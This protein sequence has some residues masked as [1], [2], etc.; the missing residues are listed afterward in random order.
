MDEEKPDSGEIDP[1]LMQNLLKIAGM[2]S[3]RQQEETGELAISRLD[4]GDRARALDLAATLIR[5]ARKEASGAAGLLDEPDPKHG[6]PH[7]DVR[8]EAPPEN[9]KR[10]ILF[11]NMVYTFKRLDPPKGGEKRIGVV[12]R[13]ETEIEVEGDEPFSLVIAEFVD[14]R[15]SPWSFEGVFFK[16]FVQAAIVGIVAGSFQ[17]KWLRE[18]WRRTRETRKFLF[19]LMPL[20]S[21]VALMIGLA[22]GLRF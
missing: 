3:P 9:K 13:W 7:V 4:P 18:E 2:A 22:I 5:Q 15:F 8:K 14:G 21:L 6:Q 11:R 20:T 19:V 10:D 17:A 12:E 16:D 1:Q